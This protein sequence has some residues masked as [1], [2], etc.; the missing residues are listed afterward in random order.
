MK[1][2]ASE[3]A[4][5]DTGK[6]EDDKDIKRL[7]KEKDKLER[8]AMVARMLQKDREQAERGKM[9]GVVETPE[10]QRAA[11]KEEERMKY[12]PAL[13]KVSRQKY[14][15][16]REEQQMDLFKRRLEDEQRIFGDQPLT[17]IERRLNELNQKL[18]ALA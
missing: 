15:E 12:V 8:D 6:R 10:Q 4:G 14:L 5:V 13:R 7:M 2:S 18:Y 17:E 9:T 3:Q 1:T 16:L 11:M